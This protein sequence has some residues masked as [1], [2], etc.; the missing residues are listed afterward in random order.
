[1]KGIYIL[2]KNSSVTTNMF[3]SY[4]LPNGANYIEVKRI[5]I[6]KKETPYSDCQADLSLSK[7]H[8]VK[9]FLDN[10]LKYEFNE[11]ADLLIQDEIT[12]TCGCANIFFRNI[13]NI[14]YCSKPEEF[15][16]IEST[17]FTSKLSTKEKNDLCPKECSSFSLDVIFSPINPLNK[18]FIRRLRNHENVISKY[19]NISNITDEQIAKSF[20]SLDVYYNSLTYTQIVEVPVYTTLNLISSIGGTLG[21]F[22]GMSVLSF[23]EIIEV[24]YSVLMLNKRNQ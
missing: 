20:V 7:S 22:L 10:K 11:C 4:A 18:E 3:E 16:C 5:F 17:G 14:R 23:I 12:R 1:M 21:L 6:Y 9:Y 15:E 2:I 24:I 13:F 19:K 8:L